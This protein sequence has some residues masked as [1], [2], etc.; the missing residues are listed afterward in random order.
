VNA[1]G[2]CR[3]SRSGASAQLEP[4]PSVEMQVNALAV[5][6]GAIS[7]MNLQDVQSG[8][9]VVKVDNHLRGE[10]GYALQQ[11]A[12]VSFRSLR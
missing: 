5:S 2:S 11:V 3:P 9:K 4:V 12:R 1:V 6:P 8:M 10:P 7:F